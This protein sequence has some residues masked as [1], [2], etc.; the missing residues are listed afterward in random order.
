MIRC[1][2]GKPHPAVAGGRFDGSMSEP[3]YLEH[4]VVR[5]D[6]WTCSSCGSTRALEVRPL[7]GAILGRIDGGCYLTDRG[8]TSVEDLLP[9]EVER[10]APIFRFR[11]ARL[12]SNDA[13]ATL[14]VALGLE[15]VRVAGTIVGRA[16]RARAA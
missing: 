3:E 6:L 8:W 9:D 1:S 7:P 12:L 16:R 15:A 14:C 13:F 10:L 2:C 5:L 4:G 11:D